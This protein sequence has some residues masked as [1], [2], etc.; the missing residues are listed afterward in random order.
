ML[1]LRQSLTCLNILA[2]LLAPHFLHAPG[3]CPNLPISEGN[4][5]PCGLYTVAVGL[6]AHPIEIMCGV[7][8]RVEVIPL[9]RHV[10]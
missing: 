6:Q 9:N 8:L 2:L 4:K 1:A 7:R 10:Q 3:F 5:S